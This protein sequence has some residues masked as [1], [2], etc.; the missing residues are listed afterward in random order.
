MSEAPRSIQHI[1]IVGGG[2]AGWMTAAALSNAL[3]GK[4]K[5]ILVESEEIGTVGV[6]EATIPMVKKFNHNLL[7]IDETDFIKATNATFKLGIEFID[8]SR[9]GHSYFHPF[10]E[11]GADFDVVPLYHY[12]LKARNEG[13]EHDLDAY[14]IAW[15]LAKKCR[16]DK[17]SSDPRLIQSKF[18]Y[19]YHFDASL[20][21]K[22]L[23][24]YSEKRGVERIEGKVN[25]VTLNQESGFISS[26]TLEDGQQISADFFF[27]CSGFRALL[28]EGAL[29]TGYESWTHWLP[30]DRAVFV[31][32]ESG[33][34]FTPYTK[35]T[36]RD[37]GWQWR[38]PLQHRI[39]NGYVYSSNHIS[40]ED[41]T[42]VLLDNL[43]G[44]PVAEPKVLLFTTG[45]RNRFWNKNCVAI[46]L[47]AGFL[48]PLESTSL[49]LIQSGITRFLALFPD[50]E[51]DDNTTQEY[52]RICTEEYETVRDFLI[53]HYHA[54]TRDDT[55]FWRMCSK[56]SIPETLKYKLE[57]F[58]RFGRL[59][60]PRADIFANASWLAVLIGQDIIPEFNNPLIEYRKGVKY[61]EN[62]ALI[63]KVIDETV[64]TFPSHRDFVDEHCKAKPG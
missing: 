41:A 32:C 7:G 40:D 24:S 6:G 5:I 18:N 23:R 35:S 56:M 60:S 38:I 11:Y 30:C 39:G 15:Q 22:Y 33:G 29:K 34:E 17:P 51:C 49:Y 63:R 10:G 47:S 4:C 44:K 12:W 55:P 20:Y 8:W 64:E 27:D 62:L 14:S 57:H 42:Q 48:E 50:A 37:A 43:D 19:A 31:P 54:T 3:Q 21:A 46:G 1:A 13:D 28:I 58:K 9:K 59:V 2:S 45:R 16:F 25:K 26:V 52:N 36:A 53:L 61:K